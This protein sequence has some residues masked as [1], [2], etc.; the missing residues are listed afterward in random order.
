M[1]LEDD[2]ETDMNTT[3][4]VIHEDAFITIDKTSKIQDGELDEVLKGAVNTS[5]E[6]SPTQ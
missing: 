5:Q 6:F 3:K 1:N 2:K 4:P